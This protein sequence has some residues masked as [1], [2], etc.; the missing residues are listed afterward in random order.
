M[1]NLVVCEAEGTGESWIDERAR[2]PKMGDV[3]K[4]VEQAVAEHDANERDELLEMAAYVLGAIVLVHITFLA[5][6]SAVA[7]AL[8]GFTPRR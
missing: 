2:T 7:W 3:L 8:I 4:S 5:A 6:G 1:T